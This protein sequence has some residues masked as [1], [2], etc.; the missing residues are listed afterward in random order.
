M[1][2]IDILDV[3]IAPWCGAEDLEGLCEYRYTLISKPVVGGT[4]RVN[5]CFAAK[6]ILE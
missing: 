4:I 3:K 1:L 2:S 6:F 5:D